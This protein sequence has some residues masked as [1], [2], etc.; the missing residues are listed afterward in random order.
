MGPAPGA[1]PHLDDSRGIETG[2]PFNNHNV[3]KLGVTLNL[4]TEEGKELFAR[5]VGISDVVVENF[6]AGVLSRMGFPYSRL[7][8]I[9]VTS[10]MR[11]VQASVMEKGPTAT[12]RRGDLSSRL[13]AGSPPGQDIP[14]CRRR[15]WGSHTWTITER[16][17]SRSGFWRP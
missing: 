16:T 14:V 6:A 12:S 5:L 8:E 17:F 15:D 11:R 9:R 7:C 10:S 4:R 3:E 2:G 1:P 13:C